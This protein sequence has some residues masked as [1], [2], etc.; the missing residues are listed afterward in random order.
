MSPY[1]CNDVKTGD[2]LHKPHNPVD[3]PIIHAQ[4]HKTSLEYPREPDDSY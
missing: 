4:P 2:H 1:T 3:N